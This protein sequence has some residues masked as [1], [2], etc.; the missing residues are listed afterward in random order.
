MRT[1]TPVSLETNSK[2][3]YNWDGYKTETYIGC[4]H[5]VCHA[6]WLADFEKLHQQ[7]MLKWFPILWR[8]ALQWSSNSSQ[9]RSFSFVSKHVSYFG[10]FGEDVLLVSFGVRPRPSCST[11][12]TVFWKLKFLFRIGF[13]P[14]CLEFWKHELMNCLLLAFRPFLLIHVVLPFPL[15][16]R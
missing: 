15:R 5:N 8:C 9:K 12:L 7:I 4:L 13:V 16:V 10:Y 1:A 14:L 3:V 6:N 11:Y 2:E